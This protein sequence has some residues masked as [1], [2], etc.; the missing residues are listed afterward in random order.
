MNGWRASEA[1]FVAADCEIGNGM[2]ATLI[3]VNMGNKA[4]ELR[5]DC[6]TPASP[7]VG[8]ALAVLVGRK[9]R[10]GRFSAAIRAVT[11]LAPAPD[12]RSGWRGRPLTP[13][14]D[15]GERERGSAELYPSHCAKLIRALGSLPISSETHTGAI[16]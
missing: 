10:A 15:L 5:G 14:D 2:D 9:G 16:A 11:D 8:R 4:L 6:M 3:G 12:P 1:T 7:H 13:L